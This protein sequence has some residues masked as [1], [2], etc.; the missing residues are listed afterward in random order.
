VGAQPVPKARRPRCTSTATTWPVGGAQTA[1]LA[2][3]TFAI[4]T[5][6]PSRTIIRLLSG[7]SSAP[8]GPGRTSNGP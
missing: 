3:R 5:G 1:R 4:G 7:V 2:Q 6:A 8:S